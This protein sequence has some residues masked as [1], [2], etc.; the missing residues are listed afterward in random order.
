MNEGIEFLCHVQIYHV[1]E[2]LLKYKIL[3]S[4]WNGMVGLNCISS[5][6]I[7]NIINPY[8]CYHDVQYSIIFN[9]VS[10]EFQTQICVKILDITIYCKTNCK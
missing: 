4:S 9:V 2:Y 10:R 7:I 8:R 1:Y 3:K 5:V 6:F